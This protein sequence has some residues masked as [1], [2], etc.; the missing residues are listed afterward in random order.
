MTFSALPDCLSARLSGT[1]VSL[2]REVLRV[3]TALS[4]AAAVREERPE[5]GLAGVLRYY[6]RRVRRVHQALAAIRGLYPQI[7]GTVAAATVA[8][9]A[10][11][12]R[13]GPSGPSV[14]SGLRQEAQSHL[15]YLPAPLGFA[16][17]RINAGRRE[18][19]RQH[20]AGAV[21]PVVVLDP[22]GRPGQPP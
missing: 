12:L 17:A 8:T 6:G 3:E 14:L 4:L 10:G 19:A 21:R 13:S 9:F 15:A 11:V 5:V 2:E 22:R 20:E 7:F 16:P 1:L 18:L